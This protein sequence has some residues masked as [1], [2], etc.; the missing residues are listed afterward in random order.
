METN[1]AFREVQMPPKARASA[2]SG[3]DL[4]LVMAPEKIY[5]HGV[6]GGAM[7]TCGRRK[8][9]EKLNRRD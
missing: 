4:P 6:N 3:A 8:G 7:S 9:A 2:A 1:A 5:I